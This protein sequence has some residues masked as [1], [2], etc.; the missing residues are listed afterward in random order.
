MLSAQEEQAQRRWFEEHWREHVPFNNE[1]GL[2]I[3][4]WEP[5]L[6]RAR[7]PYQTRLSAHDGVFHG[8]VLATAIDTIGMGAV[9]AG[10]DF[11]LGNRFTTVSL[12]VQYMAVAVNQGAIIEGVCTK[13]GRRLNFA[14]ATVM[15]EIGIVLAEGVLTVNASGQRPRVGTPEAAA[16]SDG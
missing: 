8:G 14:R 9:V 1:I 3:T 5:D 7:L 15:S 2:Q 13:R 6:V 4:D 16:P 12:T 10:H 11:S